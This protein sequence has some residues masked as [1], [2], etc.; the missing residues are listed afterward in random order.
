M[1]ESENYII[2]NETALY[3]NTQE[4]VT[5]VLNCSVCQNELCFEPEDYQLYEDW[6][7]VNTFETVLIIL[8]IIQFITGILGNLL[9][10]RVL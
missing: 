8:N 4:N 9:V 5:D 1:S 2:M 7:T 10:S 3:G 6:I